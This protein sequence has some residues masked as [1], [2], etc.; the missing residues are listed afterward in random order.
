RTV[1]INK[2]LVL[3]DFTKTTK[4]AFDYAVSLCRSGGGEIL[5][6]H[7]VD[8]ESKIPVA[9]AE[10]NEILKLEQEDVNGFTSFLVLKGDIYKDI[11]SIAE[12]AQASAIVIGKHGNT[13]LQK[14]FGS[15]VLKVISHSHIP[16]I[17]TQEVVP[18]KKI[19]NIV[20]PFNFER[21][22]LQVTQFVSSLAKK[23][24]ATIHLAGY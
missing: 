3:F 17:I 12:T 24:N 13:G 18:R 10:I 15:K 19:D 21:Q 22:S 7:L 1:E 14:I 8:E 2:Y 11:N 23:F 5:L 4:D 9:K 20:M 16:F 6:L